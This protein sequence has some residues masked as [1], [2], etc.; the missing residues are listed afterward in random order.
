MQAAFHL[1]LASLS[2]E[3]FTKKLDADRR[4]W[5]PGF[6]SDLRNQYDAVPDSEAIHGEMSC[7][8]AGGAIGN[9]SFKDAARAREFAELFERAARVGRPGTHA[10]RPQPIVSR[11]MRDAHRISLIVAAYAVR[12]GKVGPKEMDELGPFLVSLNQRDTILMALFHDI[13]R[14]DLA[15]EVAKEG[16][17]KQQ[18][19]PPSLAAV[20]A[21]LDGYD[22]SLAKPVKPARLVAFGSPLVPRESAA[23]SA[24]PEQSQR[25]TTEQIL[26][27]PAIRLGVHFVGS[28]EE[29]T[30]KIAE[31]IKT[32]GMEVVEAGQDA[33]LLIIVADAVR[34][35]ALERDGAIGSMREV[36]STAHGRPIV[37][38]SY[39]GDTE[40]KEWYEVYN[41]VLG[42]VKD[43]E[44]DGVRISSLFGDVLTSQSEVHDVKNRLY[45]IYLE[46]VAPESKT[47][48]DGLSTGR[49]STPAGTLKPVP[50]E[51]VNYYGSGSPAV[52]V[53]VTPYTV[54]HPA[55]NG[56][57][58][59]EKS[60]H[61][62][63]GAAR[64]LDVEDGATGAAPPAALPV[65]P[66]EISFS[67][68]RKSKPD[69]VLRLLN[70]AKVATFVLWDGKEEPYVSLHVTA[71]NP[72][73][74]EGRILNTVSGLGGDRVALACFKE[75]IQFQGL[76]GKIEGRL[77]PRPGRSFYTPE[78]DLR[79]AFIPVARF[80]A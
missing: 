56:P 61:T 40:E 16:R 34:L 14:P 9:D 68:F 52:R 59:D 55:S 38:L 21:F 62:P 17:K 70:A 76:D 53:P 20:D 65:V 5:L 13:G 54:T 63:S 47:A 75:I 64:S 51:E 8:F 10:S 31:K 3:V 33:P 6:I 74:E 46:I 41:M 24:P 60:P 69:A 80:L 11:Y 4:E 79:S 77:D 67:G 36:I 19:V 23:D 22:E 2:D 18:G 39:R 28:S 32:H 49:P 15:A 57:G 48:D 26:Q 73:A 43:A 27:R 35:S 71:I 12:T 58:A 29:V 45:D 25:F 66:V 72:M 7:L 30:N 50:V 78:D 42:I 1:A 37:V 44:R